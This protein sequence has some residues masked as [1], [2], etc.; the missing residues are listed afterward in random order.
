MYP[1]EDGAHEIL[2]DDLGAPTHITYHQSVLYVSVGQGTPGR[3][4]R[5][6]GERRSTAGE[7]LKITLP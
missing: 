3:P 7:L 2:A 6:D 1:P 4:I 5:V